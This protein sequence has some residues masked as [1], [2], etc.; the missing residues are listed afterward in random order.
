[1]IKNA[2]LIIQFSPTGKELYYLKKLKE[3]NNNLI[4]YYSISTNDYQYDFFR[5]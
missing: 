4:I 3:K 1:M 5:L 2:D